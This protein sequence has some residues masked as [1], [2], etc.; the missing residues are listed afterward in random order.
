MEN[1]KDL[2]PKTWV[3]Y[4]AHVIKKLIKKKKAGMD[5][6]KYN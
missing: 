5:R 4:I 2:T 1:L 6:I 3:K